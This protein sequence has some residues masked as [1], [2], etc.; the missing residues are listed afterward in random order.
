MDCASEIT[1]QTAQL[2][3]AQCLRLAAQ[4][5]ACA[6]ARRFHRAFLPSGLTNQRFS[7]MVALQSMKAARP[8]QVAK[9]LGMDQTTVTAAVNAFARRGLVGI[10]GDAEDSRAKRLS[11]TDAGRA[12]LVLAAPVWL[13]EPAALA[14]EMP[15]GEAEVLARILGGV[16]G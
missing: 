7:L 15:V 5:T 1:N 6:L 9:A 3:R 13:L 12:V 14:A 4:K 8:R 11:S 2:I 10:A 16:A